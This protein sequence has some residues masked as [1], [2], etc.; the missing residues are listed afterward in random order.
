MKGEKTT[1]IDCT[2][3]LDFRQVHRRLSLGGVHFQ[4]HPPKPIMGN[5]IY[6]QKNRRSGPRGA[7]P[8]PSN[9]QIIK[10]SSMSPPCGVP[11]LSH[12]RIVDSS[13]EKL[14][15]N[16]IRKR[17]AAATT[18]QAPTEGHNFNSVLIIPRNEFFRK[19]ILA[20]I[21]INTGKTIIFG[22]IATAIQRTAAV[23]FNNQRPLP[24]SPIPPTV[25][26]NSYQ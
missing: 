22:Q 26:I 23:L 7:A 11:I 17:A 9:G 2:I 10:E 21:L 3:L 14:I 20:V 16:N 12:G 13:K 25:Q 18:A 8:L 6:H 24:V 15:M 5:S 1:Q 4:H 19:L